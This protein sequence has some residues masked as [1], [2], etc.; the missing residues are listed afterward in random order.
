MCFY[1]FEDEKDIDTLK[2]KIKERVKKEENGC[3]TWTG[4]LN[5]SGGSPEFHYYKLRY[6]FDINKLC[7]QIYF[8]EFEFNKET[9]ELEKKCKN[10]LC[11]SKEH[12]LIKDKTISNLEEVHKK[13]LENSTRMEKTD[14]FE[15]GCLLWGGEQYKDE[16][17][18]TYVNGKNY[19]VHILALFVKENITS[20]PYNENDEKLITRHKCKNKNCAEPTHM[21]LGT[22]KDNS[23]DKKRDG[24]KLTGQNHQNSLIT[25]E[26]AEQILQSKLDKNDINYRTQ[27]DRAEFFGVSKSIVNSI[28]NGNC[29]ADTL[30]HTNEMKQKID[31]RN[32]KREEIKNEIKNNGLSESDL[33]YLK[34]KIYDKSIVQELKIDSYNNIPCRLYQGHLDVNGYPHINFKYINYFAHRII[35][36]WKNNNGNKENLH[37]LHKCNNKSCIESN[38]LFYGNDKENSRDLVK[39]GKSEQFKLNLQ[40][41]R[42]I[43]ENPDNGSS[44]GKKK[45]AESYGVSLKTI[46]S[47]LRNRSWKEE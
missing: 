42:E 27:K 4:A 34:N 6:K 18:S 47:V 29:W 39:S 16:Y 20:L 21:E 37:V 8:P 19:K 31:L 28:D 5:S 23:E 2:E 46:Y 24:T 25:N 45:L 13:L 15:M 1:T 3:E 43:R 32:K 9:Q 11:V 41:A 33:N 14:G 44:E 36:A 38:H 17:K 40:K 22:N 26:L 10:K 30:N 12:F 35:C 7:F